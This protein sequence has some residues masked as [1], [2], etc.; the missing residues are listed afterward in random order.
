M[1]VDAKCKLP[2]FA[3]QDLQIVQKFHALLLG[4]VQQ[5]AHP[6]SR[7]SNLWQWLWQSLISVLL[8]QMVQ[9]RFY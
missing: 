3:R 8:R 1:T 7:F 2:S 6:E 4:Q 9:N 5:A